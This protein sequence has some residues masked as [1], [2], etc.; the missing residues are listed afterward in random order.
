MIN[1]WMVVIVNVF[2]ATITVNSLMKGRINQFNYTCSK[3][4]QKPLQ[5]YLRINDSPDFPFLCHAFNLQYISKLKYHTELNIIST[6]NYIVHITDSF[7]LVS[8]RK[9][10]RLYLLQKKYNLGIYFVRN[11]KFNFTVRLRCSFYGITL[12]VII[13]LGGV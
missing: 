1:N 5:Y 13:I 9:T 12:I 2:T 11:C 8:A 6:K 7:L 10:Y 4:K 3:Q